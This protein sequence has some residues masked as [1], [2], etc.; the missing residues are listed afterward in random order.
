M[1]KK[2]TLLLLLCAAALAAAV[3]YFDWKRG[4]EKKPDADSSKPAFVIQAAD[5]ASFTISHPAQPAAAPIR[6]ERHAGAWQIV[7]P[8]DTAAD[9]ST[10][11]G[12]VDQLAGARFSQSEPGSADRR[13]AFGLDPPATSLEFQ[14][15]S[16][17]K[18]SLLIGNTD[19]SGA[20]VYT[21]V[22]GGQSV[23]L[24]PQLLSTSVSKSLDELRDR[25]VLHVDGEQVTSINLKN[26]GGE[27]AVSK[28]KAAK[29]AVSVDKI[30]WKFAAPAGALA[31]TDDVSS[32]IQGVAN[33]KT[34]S[35]ADEKSDN[36]AR[37]G[38]SAPAITFTS[39][40]S[41]GTKS[42]LVVGKKD[43]ATYFARDTSRPTV[44]RI[45]EDL[46][47][48]LSEKFGDLRDKR[49]LHFDAADIQRIQIENSSGS[50][51]LVR[52]QG[53][54]D[55]WIFES[56]ADKK[57]KPA[58]AWKI[59]DPIGNLR[60]EEI[61]DHPAANLATQAAFQ[62][63]KVVFTD[64][65]K[66]DLTL[67]ISKPAGDFVYVQ[68]GPSPT[69]YKLKKQILEDLTPDAATLAAADAPPN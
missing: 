13:K 58:S 40:D 62:S 16:G 5:V 38:L 6:F 48:K 63:A 33:A 27:L 44:F 50:V 64:K 54:A 10:A 53:S 20:S 26:A 57:G 1:I 31:D 52:K 43:G 9:Q 47:K 17:A 21:V 15:A 19:F 4:E 45:D 35:V 8:V 56:P 65:Y 68:A 30:E 36:L 3:Y 18:H 61:I 60:A 37:Y 25:S 49:V 51:T 39:T 23:S 55:E 24:L 59:L 29:D 7:Q 14:L 28:D 42:T 11:E 32:L 66:R 12:I 67:R 46:Y 2:T 69:L 41:N 22:D 34:V